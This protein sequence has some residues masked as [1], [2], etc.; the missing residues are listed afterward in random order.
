LFA[1][2]NNAEI[3]FVG[4]FPF[5]GVVQAKR[6]PHGLPSPAVPPS[7]LTQA[8]IMSASVSMVFI[9]TLYPIGMFSPGDVPVS[10]L[11]NSFASVNALAMDPVS[12]ELDPT[13]V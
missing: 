13:V 6:F 11:T 12:A 8:A 9:G 7:E 10:G 1:R 4:A 3:V 5:G 2:N